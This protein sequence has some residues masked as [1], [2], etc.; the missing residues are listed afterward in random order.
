MNK[1]FKGQVAIITGAGQGIGFAIAK[2]LV[3][4]GGKIV[5]NDI[6]NVLANEAVQELNQISSSSVVSLAGDASDIVVIQKMVESAIQHFGHL[7]LV[8]ANAGITI[9]ADFFEFEVFDLQKIMQVNLQS[10]F[11][12]TQRAAVQMK[13]QGSGGSIL[14][15]S[16]IVGQRAYPHATAY[17]MTKAALSM[18]AKNL[19]I[20][21]GPLGITINTISPGAT[22]T[23][24]TA[25]E[26]PDYE[27]VWKALNPNHQI[28]YPSDIAN[29]ALFLLDPASRHINGQTLTIDGGWINVG[30]NPEVHLT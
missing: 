8:V 12:L 7:D 19:V 27:G 10:A 3:R 20:E 13:K 21:L 16:S 22:L 25:L 30:R 11:F 28:A 1:R 9:F 23:E 24:R 15:M 2:A 29:A 6:N 18:M 14:L 26:D 17:A 5:L 4:E